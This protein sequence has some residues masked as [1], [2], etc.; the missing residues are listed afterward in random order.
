MRYS[1][2]VAHQLLLCKV[3]FV[4]TGFYRYFFFVGANEANHDL[5]NIHR[6]SN[7]ENGVVEIIRLIRIY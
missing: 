7:D 4:R 3:P 6:I 1:E 2:W 5:V